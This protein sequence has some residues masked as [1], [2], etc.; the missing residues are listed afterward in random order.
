M[1]GRDIRIRIGALSVGAGFDADR[2]RRM[3]ARE[4]EPDRAADRASARAV[5][6][7]IARAAGGEGS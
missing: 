6:T 1:S 4:I 2:F 7:R 5:V 3:I